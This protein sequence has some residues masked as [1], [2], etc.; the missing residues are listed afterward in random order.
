[1]DVK[2]LYNPGATGSQEL[3]KDDGMRTMS[4]QRTGKKCCYSQKNWGVTMLQF[5]SISNSPL[6]DNTFR[7]PF[8]HF[9]NKVRGI[10]FKELCPLVFTV[11]N[12]FLHASAYEYVT[13]Q[14]NKYFYVIQEKLLG[15]VANVLDSTS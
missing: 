10:F 3:E 1:M 4:H 6:T 11:L 15:V 14:T 2:Q 7:N 9:P 5:C 8:E 12:M 13:K